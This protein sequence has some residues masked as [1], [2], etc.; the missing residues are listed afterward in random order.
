MGSNDGEPHRVISAPLG[1]IKR[2]S[3]LMRTKLFAGVAFA[4]LMIPASAFAQSTGSIEAEEGE[5]IVTG[6][7]GPTVV[8]GIQTPDT[9]K[10]KAVFTQEFIERQQP[11]Q[12]IL[13]TVNFTP[14]VSFT[15]ADPYGS[16]GGNLR[17]RGFS[18]DRVSVTFDGIPLNDSGNYALYTNQQL[19]PELIEQ[20]NVNFGATEVDSPTASASGGT[21]NYRS[22]TPTD[23][24]HATLVYSHGSFDFNR[25]FGMVN[26]GTFTKFGT[27]A[28]LAASN[29]T[30]NQFRGFGSLNKEQYNAKIYQPIGNNG[31]FVAIS[32][33]YNRN[34]NSSYSNPTLTNIRTVVGATVVPVDGT[35][36]SPN[37]NNPYT[38]DLTK[39]QYDDVFFSNNTGWLYDNSCSL[40]SAVAPVGNGTAQSDSAACGNVRTTA[41]NPSNTG[42]MRLNSRF[43]I[44]EQL[45]FT[46][47]GGYTF[48]QANGGGTS[49]FFEGNNAT[50]GG[51]TLGGAGGRFA[52]PI[53]INKDG[54]TLDT[55]RVY[56]PSN[57]RTQRF[58][59][60]AGL[61]Y[62]LSD[63]SIVRVAYTWDRA[64]HRQTGEASRLDAYGNPAT[65][66]GFDGQNAASVVDANGNFLTKRNRLSYA[67][68][69]QVSGEYRGKFLDNRLNVALG[70]RAPF[71][72]RNLNNFCFT[73]PGESSNAFCS[74]APA[75]SVAAV[76]PTYAA[77][78]KHRIEK[79][80]AVLPNLGLT[81]NLV[82]RLNL[83]ASYSKGFSAPKT[84]N[85]YS[86]DGVKIQPSTV[87]KPEKTDSVDVGL[88]YSSGKIQA[89]VSGW[90]IYYKNRIVSSQ[91]QLENSTEFVSVDR[92]V[93]A[94]KSRGADAYVSF[95]PIEG[96]ALYGFGSYTKTEMQNNLVNL[97]TGLITPTKGKEVVETPK[98][99][100]G[101]RAQ[102][103]ISG[104][105][106]GV[107]AKHTGDRWISDINDLKVAGYTV[108]NLDARLG[109]DFL[110]LD[111]TFVQFNANNLFN[112][113]YFGNIPSTV[114]NGYAYTTTNTAGA[115]TVSGAAPRVAFGS[116]RS[117]TGSIH[118]E[119]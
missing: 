70:V 28:W 95:R 41:I 26:T 12:T 10:A 8:S 54:D 75:A 83:F 71:F 69:H 18:G 84:D 89:Q 85:L 49:T 6:S 36:S 25:V 1:T 45:T 38:L 66:F 62:N 88:R 34:R 102:F 114:T 82:D 113:R 52:G 64:R 96:L 58:V 74:Y 22:V 104:V 76:F 13:D 30:Y 97:Q 33:H 67:I 77:P 17:I 14:G 50:V 90:Y 35:T 68:L 47:D 23:D 109:L 19:D 103:E 61:R 63:N 56:Y 87:V 44:S 78:Y 2:E 94:V 81:Y 48:T 118:F 5:I 32:G 29:T 91:V 92:N 7:R 16:S 110:G 27:K 93:G 112:E 72:R 37:A 119:F 42:V 31:D 117:L 106:V 21:V 43:T 57:T 4:A 11:G 60:I 53:D 115:T 99:T 100:Y 80:N 86:Y 111:R 105:S 73:I 9:P 116:P 101:G 15:N 98:W 20:V 46:F 3:F 39:A 24:L 107:E 79:Y 108:V 65:V 59:A 51:I 40:N 55:V